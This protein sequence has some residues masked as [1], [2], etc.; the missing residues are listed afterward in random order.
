MSDQQKGD[1]KTELLHIKDPAALLESH[2]LDIA[3][4][5]RINRILNDLQQMYGYTYPLKVK[6]EDSKHN[7]RGQNFIIDFKHDRYKASSFPYGPKAEAF[8]GNCTLILK[9]AGGELPHVQ[10]IR[11]FLPELET[12]LLPADYQHFTALLEWAT[13]E[14]QKGRF[15]EAPAICKGYRD[16]ITGIFHHETYNKDLNNFLKRRPLQQQQYAA[17]CER[18]G[19]YYPGGNENAN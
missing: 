17:F 5:D 12:E 3:N 7:M 15:N 18:E 4:R 19:I 2:K 6:D 14:G 11:L 9:L 8:K 13:R 16:P 1:P 10:G